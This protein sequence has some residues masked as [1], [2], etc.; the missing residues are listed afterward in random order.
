MT[1]RLIMLMGALVLSIGLFFAHDAWCG[2]CAGTVCYDTC[3]TPGCVCITPPGQVMGK[4]Y[5]VGQR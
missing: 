4:C 1:F 3:Y 5:G 2:Y